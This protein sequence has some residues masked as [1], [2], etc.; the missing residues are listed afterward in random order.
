VIAGAGFQSF[1]SDPFLSP[2]GLEPGSQPTR[3]APAVSILRLT[4][5]LAQALFHFVYRSIFFFFLQIVYSKGYVSM[6]I[7]GD[8]LSLVVYSAQLWWRRVI[9]NNS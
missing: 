3:H 2:V 9:I 1:R 6:P 4:W 7:S 5:R 8:S